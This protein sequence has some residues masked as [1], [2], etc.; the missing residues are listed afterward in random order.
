LR[1][2]WARRL[3]AY[4]YGVLAVLTVGA[5]VALLPPRWMLPG[6]LANFPSIPDPAIFLI[7]WI[8]CVAGIIYAIRKYSP[9]RVAIS[10]GIIAY[11]AMA[12]LYLFA[13]PAADAYRGEKP[14]AS[15]VLATL[16]GDLG[17]LAYFRTQEGLFYLNPPAPLPQFEKVPDLTNAI[18]NK[19]IDWI[20]V[21]RKDIPAIKA[22]TEIVLSEQS[23]PWEDDDQL[24]NK[25]V[26]VRVTSR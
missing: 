6:R 23:F 15:Q 5:F 2:L 20:I 10:A 26:M 13:M 4:G 11:L 8:A 9:A 21:R 22:P 7:A 19:G 24:K 16:H 1:S 3:L 17:H 12:Y 18:Q 25:V 14:L